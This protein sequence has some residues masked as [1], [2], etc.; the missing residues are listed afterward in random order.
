MRKSQTLLPKWQDWHNIKTQNT[1]TA[2][3]R[4]FPD[5]DFKADRGFN[6]L[7]ALLKKC[8]ETGNVEGCRCNGGP[9]KLTPT[10]ERHFKHITLQKV[11]PSTFQRSLVRSW[12]SWTSYSQKKA[13][14][15]CEN[16]ARWLKFAERHWNWGAEK[17]QQVHWTKSQNLEIFGNS[18]R[19]FCSSKF[20]RAGNSEGWLKFLQCCI[21]SK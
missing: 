16:K 9:K 18:K 5:R 11:Y 20:W 6:T 8:K 12:F 3:K 21:F 7:L 4:L 17:W 2:S 1:S 13:Y 10:D 19:Q 14:L 15:Q